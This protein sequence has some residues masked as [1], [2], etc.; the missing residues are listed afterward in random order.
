MVVTE[1]AILEKPCL[2]R[3]LFERA[4]RLPEF[5]SLG[6]H[7]QFAEIQLAFGQGM[8]GYRVIDASLAEFG[9][10]TVR[11]VTA[12]RALAQIGLG[13][14]SITL[15]TALNQVVDDLLCQTGIETAR[16]QFTLDLAGAVFAPCE[17]GN[18]RGFGIL[19]RIFAQASTSSAISSSTG[20]GVT[21]SG[22]TAARIRDSIS[23]ARSGLPFRC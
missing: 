6:A 2:L 12:R 18:G 7:C 5:T 14:T 19:P 20:V 16:P 11:A 3:P 17:R 8:F 21:V 13:E 1:A 15:Q 10:D 23:C 9:T 4:R 22:I